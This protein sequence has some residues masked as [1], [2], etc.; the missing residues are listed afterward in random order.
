MRNEARIAGFAIASG[1]RD[2]NQRDGVS[3][4]RCEVGPYEICDCDIHKWSVSRIE[5]RPVSCLPCN[6]GPNN[7]LESGDRSVTKRSTTRSCQ[8][9]AK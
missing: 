4:E 5:L 3:L 6:K 1:G 8:S 2:R 9:A 7:L